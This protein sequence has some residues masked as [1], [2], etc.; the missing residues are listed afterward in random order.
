MKSVLIPYLF[1]IDRGKGMGKMVETGRRRVRKR[2]NYIYRQGFPQVGNGAHEIED[3]CLGGAQESL[4]ISS[5]SNIT[6]K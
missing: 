3:Q 6:C 4:L 5:A 1:R 2:Q